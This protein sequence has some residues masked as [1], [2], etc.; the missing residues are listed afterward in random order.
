MGRGAGSEDVAPDESDDAGDLYYGALD[1]FGEEQH[2]YLRDERVVVQYFG[3]GGEDE[4]YDDGDDP[5][6]GDGFEVFGGEPGA[7]VVVGFEG[8]EVAYDG[9][10]EDGLGDDD[11]GGGAG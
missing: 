5:S 4:G 10:G 3:K 9:W 2:L 7:L 6:E 8:G 11:D 1:E